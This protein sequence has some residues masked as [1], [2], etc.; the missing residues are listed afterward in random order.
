MFLGFQVIAS[1]KSIASIITFVAIHVK[2]LFI[3]QFITRNSKT[4]IE[5]IIDL[6]KC[7]VEIAKCI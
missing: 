1:P 7:D 4:C 5:K 6:S 2:R 3:G